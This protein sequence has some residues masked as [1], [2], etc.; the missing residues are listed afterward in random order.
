MDDNVSEHGT[1]DRYPVWKGGTI[2]PKGINGVTGVALLIN[3]IAIGF[4]HLG[5]IKSNIRTTW[6]VE[7]I[8]P[9]GVAIAICLILMLMIRHSDRIIQNSIRF[10]A[11]GLPL[12][13]HLGLIYLRTFPN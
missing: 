9:I 3:Y 13:F 1:D 2:D 11:C 5:A 8:I 6:N 12:I 7:T 10:F 4:V